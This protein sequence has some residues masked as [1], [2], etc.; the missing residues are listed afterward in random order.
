MELIR[1]I[2]EFGTP[3]DDMKKFTYYLLKVSWSSQLLFG[4]VADSGEY[5]RSFKGPEICHKIDVR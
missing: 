4:T 3:V 2:A 5:R 1:G